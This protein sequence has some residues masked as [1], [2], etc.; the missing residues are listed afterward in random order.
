VVLF[1]LSGSI[2]GLTTACLLLILGHC[3]LI[4]V[5]PAIIYLIYYGFLLNLLNLLPL[6]PTDGGQIL[7]LAL[8]RLPNVRAALRI[9]GLLILMCLLLRYLL[10]IVP[11]LSV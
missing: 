11:Q 5:S 10:R 1:F 3:Q 2:A 8:Y 6:F 4:N 7:D 9:L